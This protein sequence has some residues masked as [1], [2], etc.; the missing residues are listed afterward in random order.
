MSL[1]TRNRW[2]SGTTCEKIPDTEA[3]KELKARLDAIHAD[4]AKMDAIWTAGAAAA[5]PQ[6][7]ETQIAV[8]KEESVPVKINPAIKTSKE[9]HTLADLK[10]ERERQDAL[11]Q[12]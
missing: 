7:S 8:K 12:R 1:C 10:A 2:G 5:E 11:W 9:I 3:A 6:Q 4:R